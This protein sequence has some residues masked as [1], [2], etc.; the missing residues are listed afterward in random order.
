MG[1]KAQQTVQGIVCSANVDTV[2][3]VFGNSV[4]LLS[5]LNCLER[6]NSSLYLEYLLEGKE[7]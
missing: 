3:F 2:S 5:Y 4:L 6:S 7:N 1:T